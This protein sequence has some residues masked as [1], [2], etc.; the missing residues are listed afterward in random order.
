MATD[1]FRIKRVSLKL[2]QAWAASPNMSF[3][4]LIEAVESLAWDHYYRAMPVRYFS[5]RLMNLDDATLE[6]GL[7]DWLA[8]KRAAPTQ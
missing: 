1:P 7:N 6:A 2:E 8:G 5:A 4:Q 3:G